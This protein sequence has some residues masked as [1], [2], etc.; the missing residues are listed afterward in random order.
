M[1]LSTLAVSQDSFKLTLLHPSTAEDLVGDDG[2]PFTISLLS[3]DTNEVKKVM[4]D[5]L[6][7]ARKTM[8]GKKD[9]MTE[10]ETYLIQCRALAKGTTGCNLTL[11]GKSIKH[12]EDTMFELFSDPQFTWL[13]GQVQQAMD[14]RSNFIKS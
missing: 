14:D 10:R 8:K 1:D 11:N 6:R 9:D 12:S 2:K 7:A 4:S 13:K 3:S 5:T